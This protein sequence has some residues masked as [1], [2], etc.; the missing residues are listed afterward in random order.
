[1][2]HRSVNDTTV[3]ILAGGRSS[4]MGQDKAF[5]CLHG[6][7]LLERA[8]K[9]AE[10]VTENIFIV[11]DPEKFRTFGKVIADIYPG[12]GPLGGIHAALSNTHCD[13]N[14]VIAVDT[15]FVQTGFLEFL[16][17]QAHANQAMVNLPRTF[18]FLHPLCAVYRR[19]FGAVAETA[20]GR[21]GNKIDALFAGVDTNII[22]EKEVI[23]LGFNPDMFT[24]LNTPQ[25]LETAHDHGST[26]NILME[27]N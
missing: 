20:L 4:R 11:G 7:T 2:Y 21:N 6:Q 5:V 18:G 9:L 8:R 19:E 24:N 1:M 27:R 25:D 10:S 23:R 3:F 16:I 22:D 14:L 13:L 15:P 17:S 26:L 12:R